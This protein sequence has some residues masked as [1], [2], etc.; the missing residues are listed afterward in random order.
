MS[1]EII[2]SQFSEAERALDDRV[3]NYMLAP[4]F[5]PIDTSDLQASYKN[6]SE[7][8]SFQSKIGSELRKQ[9]EI[10]YAHASKRKLAEKALKDQS[11]ADE[12]NDANKEM[13]RL[14]GLGHSQ[15]EA[16]RSVTSQNPR[17]L[18]NDQF[19]TS[20]EYMEETFEDDDAKE[21]RERQ[22]ILDEYSH[23]RSMIKA[24]YDAAI[25]DYK[26]RNW[27]KVIEAAQV[28]LGDK[29]EDTILGKN[30]RDRAR[31]K[32]VMNH[33]TDSSLT[34]AVLR[35][36][37][38]TAG[39]SSRSRTPKE[40]E[41]REFGDL[42]STLDPEESLALIGFLDS[43][44]GLTID[45]PDWLMNHI[46]HDAEAGFIQTLPE[47]SEFEK[48]AGLVSGTVQGAIQDLADQDLNEQ[49]LEGIRNGDRNTDAANRIRAARKIVRM[50][51]SRYLLSHKEGLERE[52]LAKA[53]AAEREEF[54][55]KVT[56]I[57]GKDLTP[58]ID[59]IDEALH[60]G[61]SQG[62]Q[63][64]SKWN[65]LSIVE[66]VSTET[67][68][69][70]FD[71]EDGKKTKTA[72][73]A[74]VD[75]ALDRAWTAGA[76]VLST[77]LRSYG[78]LI[79]GQPYARKWGEKEL[80]EIFDERLRMTVE[81]VTGTREGETY[82]VMS[83]AG[84]SRA[85]R[86][87]ISEVLDELS[88]PPME[89]RDLVPYEHRVDPKR[90]SQFKTR[91]GKTKADR[92]T[93]M[94]PPRKARI[95]IRFGEHDSNWGYIFQEK[96]RDP[97]DDGSPPPPPGQSD[98]LPATGQVRIRRGQ[99]FADLARENNLTTDQ[100]KELNP[101]LAYWD[102]T[103]GQVVRLSPVATGA[104]TQERPPGENPDNDTVFS[105]WNNLKPG[106]GKKK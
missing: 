88:K 41:D 80:I 62:I 61:A 45:N 69:K 46:F 42:D 75:N 25:D 19:K 92:I 28:E 64:T 15:P 38:G 59:A 33:F 21:K 63:F 57:A 40:G 93:P 106:Y 7:S 2:S 76:E 94:Q 91:G 37:G 95:K 98:S 14:M 71:Y 51:G 6:M 43:Q 72:Q 97:K 10:V 73:A 49:V 30:M 79:E 48:N 56:S 78:P 11:N 35:R 52:K 12:T 90:I 105:N 8:M 23:D 31:N 65:Q 104:S 32:A 3:T 34:N 36:D 100:L 16:F 99:T 96:R 66:G 89:Q 24:Q 70:I 44:A 54:R 22:L 60:K 1:E 82:D 74:I 84:Y 101:G 29:W 5:T 81:D 39:S 50:G 58:A 17:L 55:N 77:I 68:L 87:F 86:S 20:Y 103:E 9:Q 85:I 53:E 4:K 26:L 13:I 27:P 47:W 83:P 102:M 18:L 67:A